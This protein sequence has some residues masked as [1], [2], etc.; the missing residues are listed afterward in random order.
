MKKI[1]QKLK[2]R[3]TDEQLRQFDTL[4]TVFFAVI[5]LIYSTEG[6]LMLLH[7][8][9]SNQVTFNVSQWLFLIFALIG[10]MIGKTKTEENQLDQKEIYVKRH[11]K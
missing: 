7:S 9:Y 8:E 5:V 2:D 4:F 1:R 3:L 10:L 6:I 11:S